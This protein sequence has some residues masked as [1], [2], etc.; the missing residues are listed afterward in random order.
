MT[1]TPPANSGKATKVDPTVLQVR[2]LLLVLG[3]G[4]AIGQTMLAWGRGA[5]PTEVLAPALTIIVFAGAVFFR[6]P[7]GLAAAAAASLLYGTV[8]SDQAGV[9]GVGVFSGLLLS[10]IA[11]YFFYAVVLSV[12]ARSV[13][14]RLHK[15]ALHDHVDD[16]T[17]LRNAAAFVIDTDTEISRS[18]RYATIF[19]IIE[20]RVASEAFDHLGKRYRLKVIREVGGLVQR[21]IRQ[22]DLGA[23]VTD[24]TGEHFLVILPETGAEGASILVSR[25]RDGVAA[26]LQSLGVKPQPGQ[27]LSASMTFPDDE[28]LIAAL[29]ADISWAAA[30][31]ALLPAA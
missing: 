10:R 26:H 5:P 9:L 6:L 18:Q 24:S 7:G 3:A 8:L 12:G 2:V 19:S 25:L 30:E 1:Q 21:S 4:L 20:V 23:R 22:M 27:V 13:E 11:T 31:A 16:L 17:G 28:L 15:L 29:R 14:Q